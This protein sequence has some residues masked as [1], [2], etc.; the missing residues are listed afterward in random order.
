MASARGMSTPATLQDVADRAGVHRS[1]VALALRDHPRIPEATR[2]RIKAVADQL[3]YRVNPFVAA[4]MQSRRVGR[5]VKHA[6]LAFVTNYPT[7]YGWRPQHHNRPDFFPGAV[8]RAKEFGYNL[9]PFWLAEPGMTPERFC[10]ILVTR[11]VH[12][13]IVGRMP[14]GQNTL[15]LAWERFSCVALGMTLRSPQLHHV[16]ENHFDTVAQAMEQCL[17]R[18]YRRIGFVFSEGNDSPRVGDRWIGAYLRHQLNLRHVDRLPLCPGAPADAATFGQ[19]FDRHRPD[20]LLVTHAPPL[21]A[22]LKERGLAVPRD[23]GLVELED[24]PGGGMAGVFYDP[25]KVGALAVEMLVGLMH[26]NE[27]G[28]PANPHEVLLVGQWRDG[29]SL[30]KLRGAV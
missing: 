22:W 28:V 9:E 19:W 23:L 24:R 25:A 6:T 5:T 16:T 2:V 29:S 14:P 11:N 17:S 21:L 13:L 15:K 27:R 26:R 30:P 18:G 1:T 3:G 8:A 12:G 7:R 10:D 20:A 4:L